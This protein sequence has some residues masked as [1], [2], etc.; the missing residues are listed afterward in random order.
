MRGLRAL[1][2]SSSSF[3]WQ[4]V[5]FWPLLCES[6]TASNM[7]PAAHGTGLSSICSPCKCLANFVQAYIFN[8]IPPRP[9]QPALPLRLAPFQASGT[10]GIPA[11][12]NGC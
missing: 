5:T 11:L 8:F 1:T 9:I 3:F 4:V 7:P 12:D 10:Q 6:L 2:N